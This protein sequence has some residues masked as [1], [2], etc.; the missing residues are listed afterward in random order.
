MPLF[1]NFAL[2][3]LLRSPS[4]FFLPIFSF[5]LPP[6]FLHMLL[7][8]SSLLSRPNR[9]PDP[10]AGHRIRLPPPP[11]ALGLPATRTTIVAPY[12]FIASAPLQPPPLRYSSAG[13]AWASGSATVSCASAPPPA[14]PSPR[15]R[16]PWPRLAQA[17][18][19]CQQPH[20]VLGLGR[21]VPHLDRRSAA[22]ALSH[23]SHKPPSWEEEEGGKDS[24]KISKWQ[25]SKLSLYIIANHELQSL[26][27]QNV[28]GHSMEW[29]ILNCP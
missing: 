19:E 29:H 21:R 6:F 8:S 25:N 27:W 11:S 2:T 15:H 3:P 18:A 5:S 10:A 26:Y 28:E 1:N 20:A 14:A 13:V 22:A 4:S 24:D 16:C 7:P 9:S 23:A 17:F 12:I